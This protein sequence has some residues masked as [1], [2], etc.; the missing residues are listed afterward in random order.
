MSE[1]FTIKLKKLAIKDNR[2]TLTKAEVNIFSF[3]STDDVEL[4]L[5]NDLYSLKTTEEQVK[6]IKAIAQDLLS[7]RQIHKFEHISDNQDL[8]FGDTGL[9]L[10]TSNKIPESFNLMLVVM[11]DDTDIRSYGKMIDSILDDKEFNI[12]VDLIAA[13][14]GN[15]VIKQI[16]Q[17][18]IGGI[19]QCMSD[20]KNDQIDVF[21][22]SLNKHFDYPKLFHNGV[23]VSGVCGNIA[24]DYGVYGI[25]YKDK[26]VNEIIQDK[27]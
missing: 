16:I 6:V 7:S 19:S 10:Y 27:T 21:M 17:Y 12:L 14:S 22:T 11:E 20:K 3:I 24:V 15:L 1:F 25:I 9:A 4:P 13:S 8:I 23:G 18:L 5:L 26:E 2:E